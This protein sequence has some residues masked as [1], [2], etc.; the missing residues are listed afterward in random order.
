MF[1]R[2]RPRYVRE[3]TALGCL[4]RVARPAG[5]LLRRRRTRRRCVGCVR[6]CV[7]VPGLSRSRT[8]GWKR[9]VP[10]GVVRERRRLDRHGAGCLGCGAGEAEHAAGRVRNRRPERDRVRSIR[11]GHHIAAVLHRD[12]GDAE[13]ALTGRA[14]RTG[15]ASGT[16]W[17][18]GTSRASGTCC[19]LG[20]LRA[21]R[22]C[23]PRSALRTRQSPRPPD[24]PRDLPRAFQADQEVQVAG[25]GP[26]ALRGWLNTRRD[27]AIVDAWPV[28]GVAGSSDRGNRGEQDHAGG[29]QQLRR[30]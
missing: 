10:P 20:A 19:A 21:C 30:W 22:A 27:D 3:S 7:G 6:G 8:R 5:P 13:L 29:R 14:L 4:V 25:R 28:G 15:R 18:S 26:I 12:R 17:A 11:Y 24:V 16:A 1:E 9:A 2:R 23:C